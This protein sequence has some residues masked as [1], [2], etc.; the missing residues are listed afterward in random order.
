MTA[1]TVSQLD[2]LGFF[3]AP[4]L[5]DESPLEPGVWLL[6][7]GAVDAPP[8]EVPE[9][10]RALWT[11]AAFDLQPIVPDP[12][13]DPPIDPVLTQFELDQLR[14]QRRAAARDGLMAYMAADNM[15]RVRSGAWTVPDL[16]TLLSDPA[17]ATAQACMS[18][19]SFELA[20]QAIGAASSP[21]I[22]PAIKADWVARLTEHFY[23]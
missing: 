12:T 8:P 1:R 16:T 7:R 2:A 11:G 9:G 14:Y 17:M 6:P 20:A 18:T 5:A 23:L 3:V 4:T 10:F 19:L 13:P 15:S 22:T 21:L